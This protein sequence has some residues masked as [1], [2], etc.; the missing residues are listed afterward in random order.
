MGCALRTIIACADTAI[1]WVEVR[2]VCP[3]LTTALSKD[4]PKRHMRAGCANRTTA[5][6][7]WHVAR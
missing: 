2:F 1:L 7:S 5:A 6:Q 4:A 3:N